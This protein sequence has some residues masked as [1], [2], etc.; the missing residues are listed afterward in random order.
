MNA[1]YVYETD[2]V[3]AVAK[4]LYEEGWTIHKI[5]VPR[6]RGNTNATNKVVN[7]LIKY[8]DKVASKT[9]AGG[10]EDIKAQ[11][12]GI[13]WKIECKGLGN[14]LNLSTIRDYFDRALASVVTYYE[15][16]IR[17]GLA[18]PW[19]K[20]H[21]LIASKIS[22]AVRERLNLWIL[23]YA[24]GSGSIVQFEPN[25]RITIPEG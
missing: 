22:S 1:Q 8:D 17:L 7:A 2:V 20:Y 19:E 14:N 21:K 23:L 4:S 3:I 24:E 13:M 11:K 6:G 5:S 9:S 25:Q 15:P 18:L 16:G 12:D 10:G